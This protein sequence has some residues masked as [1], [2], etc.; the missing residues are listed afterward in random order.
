M[1]YAL[2]GLRSGGIFSRATDFESETVH[3]C[4]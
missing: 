1:V 3:A 4:L 2:V